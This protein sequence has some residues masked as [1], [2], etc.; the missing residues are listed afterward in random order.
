LISDSSSHCY[1]KKQKTVSNIQDLIPLYVQLSSCT[2]W[3]LF[4]V[5]FT[6]NHTYLQRGES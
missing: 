3:Y 2:C 5:V 1:K 6:N 4:H